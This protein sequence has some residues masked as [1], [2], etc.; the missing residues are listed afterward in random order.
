MSE[1][2]GSR[3]RRDRIDERGEPTR[4]WIANPLLALTAP[5]HAMAGSTSSGRHSQRPSMPP[6]APVTTTTLP[7]RSVCI[8]NQSL[9]SVHAY[10]RSAEVASDTGLRRNNTDHAQA[11]GRLG[12]AMLNR[13][14]CKLASQRS[15]NWG[16]GGGDAPAGV[17]AGR[18]AA[19]SAGASG[20]RVSASG[21]RRHVRGNRI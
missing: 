19:L 9:P 16:S 20:R 1:R 18:S 5:A 7:A 21:R 4:A 8:G 11:P 12:L 10:G 6:E 13:I 2:D 14:S 3:G 17:V 15:T